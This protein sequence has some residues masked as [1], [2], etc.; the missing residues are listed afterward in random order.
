MALSKLSSTD[1]FVITDIDGEPATGV[2]RRGKK[3]LESSAQDLARSATYAFAAFGM[4]RSGAS[5]GIN[6]EGA[7]QGPA[8]AAFVAELLP[9]A[10]A[11]L[12]LDPGKGMTKTDLADLTAA[13]DRHPS[14]GS[15]A[16]TAQGVVAGAKWAC[17][18]ELAGR[19][20][21]VEG[22]GLSPLADLV[23]SALRD[24]GV[25]IVTP[26]GL[27]KKPW[28]IWAADVDL[29]LCGLKPGTL[30]HQGAAT[31]KAKAIIP[32]GPL[33]VT[34]KAF[35]MM[36]REGITVV[37]DFVAAA[38]GLIAEYLP[39]SRT[40][41]SAQLSTL[42]SNTVTDVLVACSHHPDGVFIGACERAESYLTTWTDF[43][44]FGRPLAA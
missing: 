8:T 37:P 9:R 24:A 7:D 35:V 11:G 21:A 43:R 44:P 2:V 5:A 17:D 13:A 19:T 33:P 39:N 28:L 27:D 22:L 6:A 18:G 20:A 23:A 36:R 3:I 10:S 34:T 42:A 14:A 40:M 30:T 29:L 26:E 41:D 25:T 4:Q 16:V 31:V 1:A 38:A 12:H 32:W 15:R